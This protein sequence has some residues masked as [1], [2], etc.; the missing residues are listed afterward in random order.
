MQGHGITREAGRKIAKFHRRE[1]LQP[2][3]ERN[4]DTRPVGASSPS[5]G[6][7]VFIYVVTNVT[8]TLTNYTATI[9]ELDGEVRGSLIKIGAHVNDPLKQMRDHDVGDEGYCFIQD[10]EYYALTAPCQPPAPG[11]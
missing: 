2:P 1:R 3:R 11:S 4:V 7:R 6:F 5:Q 9:Y 8:T 10:E